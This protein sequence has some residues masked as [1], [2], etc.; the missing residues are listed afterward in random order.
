MNSDKQ[1]RPARL[2]A[3]LR[4][5]R[6]ILAV[7]SL[8]AVVAVPVLL[9]VA[10]GTESTPRQAPRTVLA[11]ATRPVTEASV[12]V[13]SPKPQNVAETTV[14]TTVAPTTVAP[15]T[16][17]VTEPPTTE[18]PTT[19]PP[20]TEPPTTEPPT[21]E[22]PTTEPPTTEPP[23]TV[24]PTTEP[25][26]TQPPTTEP[27]TTQPPAPVTQPPAPAPAPAPARAQSTGNTM[28]VSATG[29]CGG[30]TTAS[31]ESAH[32]GG[33]AMNAAP[34]GSTWR[35]VGGGATYTVNDRIGHGSDFDIYF[36]SCGA[37]NAFG[38]Q[39]LTIEQVG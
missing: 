31:G 22:P 3:Y 13:T 36:S 39:T 18:P 24:P 27:P 10:G 34:L 17:P 16:V 4:Q 14:P 28:T 20:T 1:V 33:V 6:P 9:A 8:L 12:T 15:T 7:L 29:Y 21:T 37:A 2:A 5:H 19:Q 30:G 35:V 11:S 38:R 23:T 32:D 26:T 25:P